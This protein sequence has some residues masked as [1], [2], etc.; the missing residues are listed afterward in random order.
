MTDIHW[1]DESPEDA[2]VHLDPDPPSA[3]P[4]ALTT[5]QATDLFE[6]TERTALLLACLRNYTHT[7]HAIALDAALRLQPEVAGLLAKVRAFLPSCG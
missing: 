3:L 4:T 7:G 2:D 1:P 5:E 6:F